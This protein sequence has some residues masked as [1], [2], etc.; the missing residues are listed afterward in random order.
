MSAAA[1]EPAARAPVSLHIE[2][3]V[4]EGLPLSAVQIGILQ[5]AL[6]QE[7]IRLVQA[8]HDPGAPV[9]GS[10]TQP[11]AWPPQAQPQEYGRL[12]ARSLFDAVQRR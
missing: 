11:V 3:L 9:V 1:L 2:R 5:Q 4:L 12:I 8:A 10:C 6:Q 7:L